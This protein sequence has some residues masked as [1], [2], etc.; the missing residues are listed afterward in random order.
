MRRWSLGTCVALAV[1]I[2]GCGGDDSTG[3]SQTGDLIFKTDA[4]TCTGTG[5]VELFVD[6]TSQGTYTFSPGGTKGFNV[7]AGS[8]TAG[9]REIGGTA[10][11]FP[12]LNVTVPASGSYTAVLVCQ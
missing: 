3:P 6:G 1:V 11:Q 10:Y 12:T 9:A 5:N 4:N 7:S 2:A 8:H